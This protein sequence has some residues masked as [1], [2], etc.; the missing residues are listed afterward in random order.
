MGDGKEPVRTILI[1]GPTA[2]G[3]SALALALAE[4]LGA[5]VIN[6]DSM[7]VY[8]A[9]PLL[10]AQPSASDLGRAPHRLYG[11]RP[12]DDP[13]S[14]ARW[15]VLA[16]A[17]IAD[18]H[19]AGRMAL[20]VGGTGLYFRALVEG[21]AEIPDIPADVRAEVTARHAR[22]GGD[23]FRAELALHD[24]RL[25]ERLAPGDTQR[26][27]R[28]LEVFLATG[29]PLSDWQGA[30]RAGALDVPWRGLVMAPPTDVLRAR[31]LP[32]LQAMAEAGLV[33]E[34]QGF[35]ATCPDALLPLSRAVGMAPLRRHVVGEI[36]LAEALGLAE[37]D[38]RHYAKRQLTWARKHMIDWF[39]PGFAQQMESLV[40]ES[41]AFI[42]N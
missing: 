4:R 1:A 7:Q 33:A 36:G 6:A 34:V 24:P 22:L 17:A 23:A 16:R 5:E 19:A 11:T 27:I 20:L 18:A 30:G 14:A 10:T 37:I 21:L 26:L 35:L 8:A 2:S 41:L 42:R 9:L 25:A 12:P 31:F 13:C 38:T 29:R 3:K 32:R 40:A 39:W 28:G 15:A